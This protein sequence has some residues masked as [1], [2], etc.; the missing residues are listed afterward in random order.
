MRSNTNKIE[1]LRAL[2]RRDKD[3]IVHG[4]MCCL[5]NGIEPTVECVAKY[6]YNSEYYVRAVESKW[7][8]L[9]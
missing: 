9:L 4:V 5:E 2:L 3:H 7:R 6:S 8:E 1:E